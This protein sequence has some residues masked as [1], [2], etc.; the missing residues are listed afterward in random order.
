MGFLSYSHL[1]ED[2]ED[3]RIAALIQKCFVSACSIYTRCAT[4]ANIAVAF[5]ISHDAIQ[6]KAIE[7]LIEILSGISV[8]TRGAH[9]LVWV[10]FVAGAASTNQDQRLF[11]VQRMEQVYSL[12]HFQNIPIAIESLEKIWSRKDKKRWTVCLP[13]LSKVLVM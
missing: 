6:E 11:F 1:P 5:G 3:R 4:N 9:A 7:H 2:C 8:G 12:T 10:Y 13:Q